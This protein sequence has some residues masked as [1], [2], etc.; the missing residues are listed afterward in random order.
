MKTDPRLWYWDQIG[1]LLF[2]KFSNL[3]ILLCSFHV[4]MDIWTCFCF[5]S[6]YYKHF[7]IATYHPKTCQNSFSVFGGKVTE[8]DFFHLCKVTQC[9]GKQNFCPWGKTNEFF[10]PSS[11]CKLIPLEWGV[12]PPTPTQLC[13]RW[14]LI[15]RMPRSDGVTLREQLVCSQWTIHQLSPS[16]FQKIQ[17]SWKKNSVGQR[18]DDIRIISLEK[19]KGFK[20]STSVAV[21]ISNY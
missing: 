8:P 17:C 16:C 21:E 9:F 4:H 14:V 1:F 3:Q 7:S 18:Q 2:T 13:L 11:L 10:F 6:F 12:P 20:Y 15:L 19:G 5:Y